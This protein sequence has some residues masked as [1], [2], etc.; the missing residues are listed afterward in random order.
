MLWKRSGSF[1][2]YL[3]FKVSFSCMHV[4]VYDLINHLHTFAARDYW[5]S[6]RSLVVD[7]G[8]RYW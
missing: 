7:V 5:F 6:Q 2:P 8:G 4:Q 3:V 1:F